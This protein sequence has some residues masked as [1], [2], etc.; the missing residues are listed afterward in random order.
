MN[1]Q[2][3]T[4]LDQFKGQRV[5]VIGD[6]IL[7]VYLDGNCDRL[8]PEFNVPVLDITSQQYCLGGAANVAANLHALGSHV[9]YMSVLGQDHNAKIA[10]ELLKEKGID[11]ICLHFTTLSPTLSKTRLSKDEQLLY[12]FDV[13]KKMELDQTVMDGFL[14]DLQK[15][16]Y[17]YDAVYIADYEKGT[18]NHQVI[19]LLQEMQEKC[20]KPIAIDAKQYDKYKQ[21]HPL[22][23]KPNHQE[24][25]QILKEEPM[26][27]R[28]EQA[29][30]WSKSMHDLSN[31]KIVAFTLDS[32]GVVISRKDHPLFH[33]KVSNIKA[34]NVSGAGDTF[35]SAFL[36]AHISGATDADAVQIA[37]I[38]ASVSIQK[39]I[40]ASC[41]ASELLFALLTQKG[42]I[43]DAGSV[44]PCFSHIL[45]EHKKVVFTNGCF[46]IFHSGHIQYL[47]QARSLGDIL[48]V[49]INT[50]ESVQRLKGPHRPVNTLEDRMEV[51]KGLSCIDYIIPFGTIGNDTPI[52][53]I[54]SIQPAIYVKGEDYKDE[55][56]P[57]ASLLESLG[58]EIIFLPYVPHQSTTKIIARVQKNDQVKLKKIS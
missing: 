27:D 47:Q 23:I 46:D 42:K 8:A 26:E 53:L 3:K 14:K 18:I 4:I 57:E 1:T 15:A 45:A 11:S 56:L 20:F 44:A 36:L 21:L 34:Q 5:L 41:G 7:D 49:G 55:H 43:L 32:D 13:G 48:V 19:H 2:I 52:D 35:L 54:A 50:D 29:M 16:Y 17:N 24:A 22:I 10:I 40:T 58:I 31:A 9:C 39:K 30:G 38:A 25:L 37:S 12:R 6:F 51:L 28:V 33:Y